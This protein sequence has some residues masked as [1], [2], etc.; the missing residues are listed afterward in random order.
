MKKKKKNGKRIKKQKKWKAKKQKTALNCK[1][2]ANIARQLSVAW[3]LGNLNLAI[4][5][6]QMAIYALL[7]RTGSIPGWTAG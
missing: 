6:V 1:R 3:R 7:P 2:R 4:E 5:I